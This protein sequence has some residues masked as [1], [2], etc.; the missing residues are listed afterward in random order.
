MSKT[1]GII[2]AGGKATRMGR[3]KALVEFRSAPMIRQVA[4]ALDAAGLGVLV[5]GRDDS[6][7]GLSAIPDVPHLTGGPAVGLLTALR[8]PD[9]NDVFLVAVDQPLLRP[10]TI[11]EMLD[12]AGDIVVPVAAGHP[13]VTCALYRQTC[14]GPLDAMLAAGERKLRRLL[15]VVGTTRIDEGVWSGWDEDGRS[16]MSLDTPEAV[17]EAEALR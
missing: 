1:T 6:V 7:D 14:L 2:L 16:W 17:R 9:V 11:A 5:V 15:D 10:A 13:Q 4:A 12:K 8:H 3:D